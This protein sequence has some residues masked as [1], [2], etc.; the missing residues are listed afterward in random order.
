MT[1]IREALR[2]RILLLDGAMGTEI[3]RY[4]LTEADFSAAL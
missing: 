4:A 3:Q 1:V 2:D